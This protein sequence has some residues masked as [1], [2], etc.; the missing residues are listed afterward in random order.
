MKITGRER[1]CLRWQS[2]ESFQAVP[3]PEP[4]HWQPCTSSL[5]EEWPWA[6]RSCKVPWVSSLYSFVSGCHL[7]ELRLRQDETSWRHLGQER[8]NYSVKK[9]PVKK[10]P[11]QTVVSSFKSIEPFSLQN[12]RKQLPESCQADA[13]H[14]TA[15]HR[16]LKFLSRGGYRA[17]ACTVREKPHPVCSELSSSSRAPGV[18][19]GAR[20]GS[21]SHVDLLLPW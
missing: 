4:V 18:P 17:T 16:D 11:N 20:G 5:C 3:A 2:S 13:N 12:N 8:K 10:K 14:L 1:L 15:N 9:C 19:A 6:E 21:S 7:T